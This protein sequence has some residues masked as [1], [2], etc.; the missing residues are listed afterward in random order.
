MKR[1][2][3]T[4]LLLSVILAVMLIG[5]FSLAQVQARTLVL[6]H[7]AAPGNPRT[8]AADVFAKLVSEATGGNLT[9]D[10]QGSEKLGSDVEML[11]AI[12]VGGLDLT[13]NSQGPLGTFVPEVVLFGLP[14]LFA[15]PPDAWSLLDGPIGDQMA[16]LCEQKAF[17]V[18][19]WWDNGIRH[20]SNN[21]RPIKK[22]EDL[23]GIKLRT[24]QDPITIDIFKALGANP[25][26]IAFGELY[27]ALR[28]GTVDGQEN[29]LV[30]IWA[31]KLYEVQKY[32]SMT[33]HKYECTPFIIS[34]NAWKS[35]SPEEQ[36]A[37][38]NAAKL[39]G[40]YQRLELVRQDGELRSK[41]EAA[42]LKINDVNK[43]P[44]RE[45]TA[46]VYDQWK[47]KYPKLVDEIMQA[48]E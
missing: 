46:G 40:T 24:P 11:Q 16:A 28:Q 1:F 4:R 10:I 21:V 41:L 6:G 38:Q 31:S 27:L 19:A 29:P 34:V 17:K 44:F 3:R 32:I 47:A 30:N 8:L 26:P 15:Q 33:G 39:A 42:G 7:G 43:A 22:P 14:F 20:V 37:V 13:A 9:I 25:T 18:L 23:K 45:A 2:T 36:K 5:P 35:L 12:Q 48:R